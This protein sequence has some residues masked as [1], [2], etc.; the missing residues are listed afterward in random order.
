MDYSAKKIEAMIFII[1]GIRVMLD[2]DLAKLYEV[3]T[4]VLNQAVRRN[5][6]RFPEDF[7]F[8]C[9]SSDL[10]YLRS[11]IVTANSPTHWNYKRRTMPMFFTENG[12]AML[13]TVLNSNR[14]LQ[15]NIAI[16]RTFTRLRSFLA[17][18]SSIENRVCELK[19]ET[20]QLFKIVF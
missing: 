2:S 11:Q 6:E 15:V 7:M 8:E 9:N 17:M 12:V 3:E 19:K 5:L 13:S 16:M 14:A 1:R 18:E 10:E 4:K 20:N